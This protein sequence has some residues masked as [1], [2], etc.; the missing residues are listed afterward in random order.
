M[1]VQDGHC[2]VTKIVRDGH[3][4]VTKKV[5]DGHCLVLKTVHTKIVRDGHC[6]VTKIV[7]DDHSLL[8]LGRNLSGLLNIW[9]VSWKNGSLDIIW[10]T[11]PS[12]D[13]MAW[14]KVL[15]G[16]FVG[17]FCCFKGKWYSFRGGNCQN[18]FG[19]SI[20][21][22]CFVSLLKRGLLKGKNLLPW[23]QILSF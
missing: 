16:L 5:R 14:L 1:I 3:C 21:Q 17:I 23:E 11:Y 19:S 22:N 18:C 7:Q 12:G 8:Q 9:A 10:T 4:L 20:C 2:L 6:L 13:R 15:S